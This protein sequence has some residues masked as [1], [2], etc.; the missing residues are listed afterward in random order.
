MI[1]KVT[2]YVYYSENNQISIQNILFI[3]NNNKQIQLYN[4][5]YLQ[6]KSHI[7]YH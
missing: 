2:K 3:F 1:E 7:Y 4:N 5:P 6:T